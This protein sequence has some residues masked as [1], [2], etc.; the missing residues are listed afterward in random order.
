MMGH[1][2]TRDKNE[3]KKEYEGTGRSPILDR[4]EM[5]KSGGKDFKNEATHKKTEHKSAGHEIVKHAGLDLSDKKTENIAFAESTIGYSDYELYQ[6]LEENDY[7]TSRENLQILKEGLDSGKY[8][9]IEQ[10]K[11]ED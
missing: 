8:T 5:D 9:I 4:G 2:Y 10:I 3:Q 1:S 7:K 6:I 11:D